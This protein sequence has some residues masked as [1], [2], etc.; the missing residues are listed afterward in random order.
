MSVESKVHRRIEEHVRIAEQLGAEAGAKIAT[1][2]ETV[3]TVLERGGRLFFCGNGGSAADA[4]HLAAE[5]VV[6]FRRERRAFSA[7]ALTTDSSVLTASAN[8]LGYTMVFVRQLEAWGQ[9]G[10]LLFLHTTSG[11][12]ENLLAVAEVARRLRIGTV[13]MTAG[14]GGRLAA[15]V[16]DAID[17]PTTS[18]ARAQEMHI[19]IGHIICDLVEEVLSGSDD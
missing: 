6:R 17:V 4:Q 9:E 18:T 11:E 15:V 1:I 10:D 8:D 12:S 7:M 5:Y 19:L 14:G 2:A 13:A 16:D 3:T